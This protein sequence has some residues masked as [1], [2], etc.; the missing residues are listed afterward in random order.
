VYHVELSPPGSV[1]RAPVRLLKAAVRRLL[2]PVLG[3]QVEF[4]AAVARLARETDQRLQALAE[5]QEELRALVAEQAEE[6]RRLRER[7]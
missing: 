4:N 6:L 2:A 7:P 3:R 5:R 1:L